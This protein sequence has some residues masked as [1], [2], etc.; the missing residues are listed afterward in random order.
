[1]VRGPSYS[2]GAPV[3]SY[4]NREAQITQ[5][6]IQNNNNNSNIRNNNNY[7][8][9]ISVV[10]REEAAGKRFSVRFF[11]QIEPLSFVGRS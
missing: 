10:K 2:A 3:R 5:Q 8:N 1:M 9:K 6:K 7:N 4:F 11:E